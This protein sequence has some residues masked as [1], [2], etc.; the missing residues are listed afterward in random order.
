[1]IGNGMFGYYAKEAVLD[2]ITVIGLDKF[3]GEAF[4]KVEGKDREKI[5]DDYVKWDAN[6][7]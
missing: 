2:D 5:K 6:K 7:K 3:D 1:M 4:F